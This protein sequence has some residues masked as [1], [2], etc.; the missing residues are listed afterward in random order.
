MKKYYILLFI[1]SCTC[2]KYKGSKDSLTY[3]SI[4][5][6]FDGYSEH[7]E[8]TEDIV[9]SVS[10]FLKVKELNNL[11]N[12]SKRRWFSGSKGTE[13]I[14]SLV[15]KDS[16]SGEKLL[17]RII[18]D[19]NS[20]PVIEYGVGTIFDG[21]YKNEELYNYVASVINLEEIKKY[22]APLSQEEYDRLI[23]YP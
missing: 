7:Y 14:I 16:N 13:Y 21:K 6:I 23:G 10:N 8:T 3:N 11:K 4:D 19:I 20:Q 22:E 9:I 15:Y 5:I 2:S 18:V 12:V 1:L 17:L